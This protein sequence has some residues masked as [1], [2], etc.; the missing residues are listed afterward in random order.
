MKR[1]STVPGGEGVRGDAAY[2]YDDI[3]AMR[4]A[5]LQ[6]V[7]FDC[8]EFDLFDAEEVLADFRFARFA[9]WP[10]DNYVTA[11]N[12]LTAFDLLLSWKTESCWLWDYL[13]DVM[14]EDYNYTQDDVE[15]IKAGGATDAFV[16]GEF[17]RIATLVPPVSDCYE[18]DIAERFCA[19]FPSRSFVFGTVA[20]S[21]GVSTAIQSIICSYLYR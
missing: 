19:R 1:K 15:E 6:S 20:T 12:M 13:T 2:G 4:K 8:V 18:D 10:Q 14:Y 3:R 9:A 16:Q 17:S 5:V 11:R 21:L 7:D